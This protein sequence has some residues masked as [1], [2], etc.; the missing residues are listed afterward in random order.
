LFLVAGVLACLFILGYRTRGAAVLLW[1]LTL[2]LH[3]RNPMV[4]YGADQLLRLLLFWS[5]FLPLGARWSFD[6]VSQRAKDHATQGIL[7]VGSVALVAQIFFI[8]FFAA[9]LKSGDA[10]RDGTAVYYALNID[11]WVTPLGRFLTGFEGLMAWGTYGTYYLELIGPFFL[12]CP[13]FTS[14]VR[15]GAIVLFILMQISFGL[16]LKLGI[17]PFTAIIALLPLLP[18]WFWQ[19]WPQGWRVHRFNRRPLGP[20]E[21]K[22]AQVRALRWC[23]TLGCIFMI[24]YVLVLNL[25]SLPKYQ[26]MMPKR[27]LWI[28]ETLRV[29]QNWDLFAPY[30]LTD[31]GW[32]VMPARRMDGSEFDLMTGQ[33]VS[34]QKPES[35]VDQHWG[36]RWQQYLFNL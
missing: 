28:S 18:G 30:P 26:G 3:N 35:V 19:R 16:C 22:T 32:Y 36:D 14:P 13:F 8:Y 5:L 29:D 27:L 23:A 12:I 1:G 25:E 17:F 34:W 15:T 6:S 21:I 33:V 4:L 24:T 9:L 2:S 7:S 10:W 31:D 11:Q 20:P